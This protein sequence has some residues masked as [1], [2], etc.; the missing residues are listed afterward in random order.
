MNVLHVYGFG[1]HDMD[2]VC[3]GEKRGGERGRRELRRERE[4]E[5]GRKGEREEGGRNIEF[6]IISFFFL[7]Q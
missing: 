3:E 2:S 4:R 7:H 1:V 5:R 6:K